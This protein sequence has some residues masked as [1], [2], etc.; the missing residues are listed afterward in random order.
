[1]IEKWKIAV[2]EFLKNYEEDDDIIGALLCGSYATGNQNQYSDIDIYLISKNSCTYRERGNTESNSYLI[3][4]FINPIYKIEEYMEEEHLTGG[5]STTNIFAY[6]KI[7]YDLDGSVKKLQDKA[8]EYVD[9]PLENIKSYKLD[10]N[11]YSLWNS[12]DE[13]KL[14]LETD[15]PE[16]NL[17]YFNIL[18]DIYEFYCEYENIP[19]IPK[20]K[21]YKILTDE[22]YRR[23]YHVYKIPEDVFL[24][25]YIKCF[26]IQKPETMYKNIEDLVNFYYKKQGGFNIRTF[27]LR[28]NIERK[29]NN[30]KYKRR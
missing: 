5:M 11:N 26:E 4:Y 22:Q 2:K 1:M 10:M 18:S 14:C 9:K 21:I 6:G 15:N 30:D 27:K 8:L 12:L 25:K 17:I 28:T 7:I 13:L 16:F 29:D 20:T 3:E 19:K 23:N 24:K